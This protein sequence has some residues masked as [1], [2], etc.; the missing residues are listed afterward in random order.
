[1]NY[2]LP[3]LFLIFSMTAY[4]QVEVADIFSDNMV[5]Q[6]GVPIPVWGNAKPGE[7]IRVQLNGDKA[8]T[9]TDKNGQWRVSLK[10]QKASAK[11]SQLAVIGSTK[12]QFKNVLIGEVWMA[13]GQSNMEWKLK[14]CVKNLP[15]LKS[16]LDKADFPQIRYRAIKVKE[17]LQRQ[18]RINDKQQ[19][20]VCNPQ[21]AANFSGVAFYFARKLYAELKVQIGIIECAW[22]GHPI[23]PFIPR[24]AFTGHKVLEQEAKL[25]DAGDL[26][27]LKNMIGGVFARN[28]SWLPGTVYNS[29]I[30]PIVP[31]PIKGALWYQA[32][33]NCGKAEDPRFYSEKM[34]ALMNGWRTAWGNADMPIYYVQLPQFKSANWV[35]MRNEQR[36]A[37]DNEKTGMV[38]TIDLEMN[39]IHPPNKLDVG[40]RL[41]LL[42]LKK[43]Y[44]QKIQAQGPLFKDFKVDGQKLIISFTETGSGLAAGKKIDLKPTVITEDKVIH[45][46]ELGDANG[47]W[48]PADARIVDNKIVCTS[49]LKS[50]VA[51][52]YGWATHMPED[53]QW[54]LYNKEGLPASPF[55]SDLKYANFKLAE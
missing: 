42:P 54:N 55:I 46:F 30:A 31:Y 19:W 21:T 52:R 10:A 28:N 20:Q 47:Y 17:Q 43:D 36:L 26:A 9:V 37:L 53:Q 22:G 4:S 2:I 12:I 49:E 14:Q 13:S 35:Y 40:E 33:S 27:S 39:G 24:E 29:R 18:T 16:D 45:G 5:L 44:G 3:L 34:K 23:E 32:E 11:G 51:V 38:V 48:R 6:Q 1:M 8:E 25:G 50:P 15:A 41:A 7:K